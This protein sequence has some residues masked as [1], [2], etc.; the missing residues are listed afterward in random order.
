M[1]V[2]NGIVDRISSQLAH[3]L[4]LSISD[5]APFVRKTNHNQFSFVTSRLKLPDEV[6]TSV[7]NGFQCDDVVTRVEHVRIHIYFYVNWFA[8][9]A[10]IVPNVIRA[11]DVY[12]HNDSGH[13]KTVVVEYSSP[14]IAKLFHAGHLR[15]TI[16]GNFVK[17]VYKA[18]GWSVVSI[19]YLGDWG[20]QYGLLAVGYKKYGD[21]ALLQKDAIRHLFDVYVAIC[22]DATKDATI[23]EE[24]RVYF[25]KLE[26]GEAEATSLWEKFRALSIAKYEQ[27]YARL[28]VQF[29]VYDGESRVSPQDIASVMERLRTVGRLQESDGAIIVDLEKQGLGRAIV[30]KSDGTSIYLARDVG[31]SLWR[32]RQFAFDKM[33]YVVA[34]A[35]NLH[36]R[37]LFT[38][39]NLAGYDFADKCQHVSFGLVKGMSTRRNNVIFLEDVLDTA[40]DKMLEVMKKSP[41]KYAKISDPEGVAERIGISAIYVQDMNAKRIKDYEFNW[42]RMLSFEGDTGPYLQYQHTRLCSMER[43]TGICADQIDLDKVAWILL[44]EDEMTVILSL[45]CEFP[46]LVRT[47]LD[48]LEPSAVVHYAIHLARAIGKAWKTIWVK[49][50]QPEIQLARSAVYGAARITLANALRLIGLEPL[51]RM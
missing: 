11:N 2:A 50:R 28:N 24:A 43:E 26:E 10:T 18:N 19:N 20:K 39:L 22:S 40:K 29:D 42:D 36:F 35:Q 30:E 13:G 7:V 51:E 15:S 16:I 48:T 14:N 25:K 45:I 1:D 9:C 37:Q 44:K 27:I 4:S 5:I 3:L 8:L 46:G 21:D 47:T 38:I 41:E 49:D 23:H 12:G 17:N 31:A 6:I 33:L 32:H 34:S